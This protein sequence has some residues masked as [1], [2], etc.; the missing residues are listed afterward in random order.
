MRI[1]ITGSA[2]FIGSV[3]TVRAAEQ[4]HE[5]LALDDL[6]RGL[7]H[8]NLFDR[9]R[10][11]V[12]ERMRS[13]RPSDASLIAAT[14][15]PRAHPFPTALPPDVGQR[16]MALKHDC[17]AGFAEALQTG[18][19]SGLLRD[20][21]M[22]VDAVVHLAAGTGSLDRPYEELV[23]L[24]VEMTKRV[25]QDAKDLGAKV[26]AFPTTSLGT[27]PAL[28]ESPYVKSKEDAMNW[29]LGQTDGPKLVP[30]R[31]FNVAGSY[32]GRSEKRQREVHLIPTVVECYRNGKTLVI[33]GDDYPDTPDGTPGRD[34]IHV[35]D[36][37]DAILAMVTRAAQGLS[38][39]P[40]QTDGAIWLGT[41]W[42]TSTLEV[43]RI[44]EQWVGPVAH[45]IG[46]R[47][48]FDC[49]ALQC[50]THATYGIEGLLRRPLAPAWVSVRDEALELLGT[51]P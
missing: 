23:G 3:L 26:F 22:S 27:V 50:P 20:A 6:S 2:G 33:N 12:I 31:F 21:P 14:A 10:A 29:L 47:R 37:C 34:F 35:L 16:I 36:V 17:H 1:V 43:L 5:V 39:P 48:A 38:L 24:N 32:K 4:G 8:L 30:A 51:A 18:A 44:F 19:R 28:A 9:E 46:P 49:G 15:H 7:N 42:V 40:R 13:T 25:W 45:E 41:G 11:D